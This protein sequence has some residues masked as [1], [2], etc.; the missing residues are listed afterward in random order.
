MVKVALVEKV[1]S[2]RLLDKPWV[3]DIDATVK[4]L[5]GRQEGA[6]LGYNP[7]KPGRP[8]CEGPIGCMCSSELSLRDWEL[9]HPQNSQGTQPDEHP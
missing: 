9:P 4:P 6:E 2:P 1:L 8:S 7:A 3:L 5:Y